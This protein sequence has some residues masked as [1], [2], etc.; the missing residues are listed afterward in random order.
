VE[1]DGEDE[2]DPVNRARIPDTSLKDALASLVEKESGARVAAMVGKLSTAQQLVLHLHYVEE[3]NFREIAMVMDISESRATQ[4]H[5][6]AVLALRGRIRLA[7]P[8]HAE[9]TR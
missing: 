9:V 3:L 8:S 5:S 2:G 7:S 4:L 1:S 6:A